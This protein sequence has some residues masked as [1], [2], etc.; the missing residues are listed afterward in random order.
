[1]KPPFNSMGGKSRI[2]KTIC[3]MYPKHNLYI[4]PFAGAGSCL[5][6]KHPSTKEWLNDLDDN[7]FAVHTFLRDAHYS[8]LSKWAEN[9]DWIL[10][11]ESYAKAHLPTKNLGEKA[12]RFIIKR[13]GSF[14]S[15]D[16]RL[17]RN[18]LG[19][20]L[21][22]VK[23]IPKWHERLKNVKI[24][25]LDA[26]ELIKQNDNLGTLFFIDPPYPKANEKSEIWRNYTMD[27]LKELISIL[28]NIRNADWLYAE[29]ES[30]I[31]YIPDRWSARYLQ[32][33]VPS[34]SGKRRLQT[35]VIY[36]SDNVLRQADKIGIP[37]ERIQ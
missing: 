7:I 33:I 12:R 11:E 36:G 14:A 18:K 19:K 37:K 10:S 35:E 1:M 34:F 6:A 17:Y 2:A 30:I 26:H 31:P 3:S 20:S 16:H 15:Q 25:Q 23:M 8:E 24:T 13:K 21:S 9:K 28:D 4:E 29:T 32:R 27:V 22:P 5:F